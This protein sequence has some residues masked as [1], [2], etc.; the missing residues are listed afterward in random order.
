MYKSTWDSTQSTYYFPEVLLLAVPTK[1]RG[2]SPTRFDDLINILAEKAKYIFTFPY[3]IVMLLV[4]PQPISKIWLKIGILP[5]FLGLNFEK[6][7]HDLWETQIPSHCNCGFSPK[8]GDRK[9][10]SAVRIASSAA[11]YLMWM[12]L[13]RK[14]N[15]WNLQ[16]THLDRK[17]IWTKSPGKYVPY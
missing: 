1:G 9:A 13:G 14:I 7:K 3:A 16:L 12:M 17:M 10:P 15:G 8:A 6:K 2:C 4:K 5:N 11:K